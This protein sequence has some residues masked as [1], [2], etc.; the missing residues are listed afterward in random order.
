M[1]TYDYV[2][3]QCGHKEE[4]FYPHPKTAPEYHFCDEIVD[5]DENGVY[6]CRGKLRRQIGA[7]A[8][9]IFK[10]P[11]FYST[12]YRSGTLPKEDQ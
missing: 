10:G 1:P 3:D 12:D 5:A 6:R 11:G 8:G 7:G 2:C 9:A 4:H